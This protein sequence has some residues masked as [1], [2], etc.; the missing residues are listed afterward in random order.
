MLNEIS[1]YS[2]PVP[3]C[4]IYCGGCP[5]FK[6][7]KK[8]CQGMADGCLKRQCKGIYECC[9]NKKGLKY[10]YQCEIFPCSRFNQFSSR[11]LKYEQDLLV[12]QKMIKHFGEEYLKVYYI[13]KHEV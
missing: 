8:A 5:V 7:S 9:V 12:N 13:K 2:G 10:C 1:I 3:P 4:G 6:R 11:W